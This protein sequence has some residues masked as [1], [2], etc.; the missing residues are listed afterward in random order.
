MFEILQFNGS[1]QHILE[2]CDLFRVDV[3][4]GEAKEEKDAGNKVTSWP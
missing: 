1:V 4:L 2:Q 3:E